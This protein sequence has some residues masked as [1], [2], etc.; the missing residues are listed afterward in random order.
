MDIDGL[1]AATAVPFTHYYIL[2]PP[3]FT[4]VHVSAA[5]PM[6]GRG[7]YEVLNFKT[8]DQKEKKLQPSVFEHDRYHSLVSPLN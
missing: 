1:A 8:T 3:L 4:C 6:I 2:P 7:N 5:T